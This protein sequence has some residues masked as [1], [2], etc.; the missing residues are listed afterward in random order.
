M[1]YPTNEI[2]D[3]Y[4]NLTQRN[5]ILSYVGMFNFN[6]SNNFL[7]MFKK[8]VNQFNI[9]LLS[10]KKLYN[11]MVEAL[12]NICKHNVASSSEIHPPGLFFLEHYDYGFKITTGNLI[13]SD[14]M[15][16]LKNRLDKINSSEI[17]TIKS[18]YKENIVN[19]TL[20][21]NGTAGLGFFDM[22][23]KSGNTLDYTFKKVDDNYHFFTF[24]V[25]VN[26][27]IEK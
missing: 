23:I 12:D 19:T 25:N 11:V 20:T 7:I 4:S 24:S 2:F 27:E 5:V 8:H 17:D 10:K 3:L 14:K 6:I 18:N 15:E 26:T 22:A 13:F 21:D 9:K 16:K 1:A